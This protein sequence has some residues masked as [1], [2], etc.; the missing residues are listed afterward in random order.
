MLKLEQLPTGFD[1]RIITMRVPLIQ[2]RYVTFVSVHAPTM[3]AT[4]D[5]T[6]AFY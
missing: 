3:T 6:L 1:D 2:N 4:D 5:E